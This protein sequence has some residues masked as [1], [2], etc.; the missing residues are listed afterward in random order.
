MDFWIKA[1]CLHDKPQE[2][3]CV[4]GVGRNPRD[5]L[6]SLQVSTGDDEWAFEPQAEVGGESGMVDVVGGGEE[7]LPVDGIEQALRREKNESL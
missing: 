5:R 2:V 7:R 3:L 6:Q 4:A 1:S